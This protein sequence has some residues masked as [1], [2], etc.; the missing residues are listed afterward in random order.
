MTL[1][2]PH[3]TLCTLRSILY[4]LYFTITLC[5]LRSTLTT[6]HSA[7]HIPHSKQPANREAR[8]AARP[9]GQPGRPTVHGQGHG[10]LHFHVERA[11]AYLSFSTS[12]FHCVAFPCA[13]K[14]PLRYT[15]WTFESSPLTCHAT[16]YAEFLHPLSATVH[17]HMICSHPRPRIKSDSETSPDCATLIA[18]LFGR[19]VQL[20]CTA[21]NFK[22]ILSA[23]TQMQRYLDSPM[24]LQ[25]DL[26]CSPG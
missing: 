3:C 25:V 16:G 6:L 15:R 18:Q 17:A 22:C 8:P 21:S 11:C 5:I 10:Q 2:T 26:E 20:A 23:H 13:S 9:A 1:H 4:T 12:V 14:G 24:E 7:L 19:I